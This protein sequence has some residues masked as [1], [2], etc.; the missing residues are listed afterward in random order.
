MDFYN[1]IGEIDDDPHDVNIPKYEWTHMV[2]GSGMSN[3][4]FLNP[5]KINKVNI[6][7]SRESKVFQ[8]WRLL[9][10]WNC[11]EDYRPTAWVSRSIPHQVFWNEGN[12]LRSWR[13]ENP[14]ES[15]C[16]TY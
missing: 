8:Y 2:E 16:K 7:S 15:Q 12:C 11:W 5:L 1:V 14:I 6:S 13:N 3:D 10:W 4:K 9:E